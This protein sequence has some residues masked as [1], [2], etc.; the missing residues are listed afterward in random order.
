MDVLPLEKLKDGDQFW[1]VEPQGTPLPLQSF[2]PQ[3]F[4]TMFNGPVR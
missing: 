1:S 4:T 3:A 2:Q